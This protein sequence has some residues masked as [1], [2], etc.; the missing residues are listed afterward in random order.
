M[1]L[2]RQNTDFAAGF[3]FL[4]RLGYDFL[5]RRFCFAVLCVVAGGEDVINGGILA[6]LLRHNPGHAACGLFV[7]I[8]DAAILQP[9]EK[10]GEGEA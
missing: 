3:Y 8:I 2:A 7:R 5:S 6:L 1:V 9:A 10:Q 4:E